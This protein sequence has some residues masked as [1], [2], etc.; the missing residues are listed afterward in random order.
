MLLVHDAKE[1]DESIRTGVLFRGVGEKS[2][3]PSV[4]STRAGAPW[5]DC[6]SGSS[7]KLLGCVVTLKKCQDCTYLACLR[8]IERTPDGRLPNHL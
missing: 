8:G 3:R 6:Q 2:S 7:I 4:T 1:G 5:Q